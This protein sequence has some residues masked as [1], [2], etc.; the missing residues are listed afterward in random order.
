MFLSWW[1]NKTQSFSLLLWIT[2]L[3]LK[4]FQWPA[5]KTLKRWFLH[6]KGSRLWFCKIIP[7]ATCDKSILAHFPF[8]QWEV[9]TRE[10]RPIKE[11]LI[12]INI[13]KISKKF[14]RSKQKVNSWIGYWKA[15]ERPWKPSAH[16]QKVLIRMFRPSNKYQSRDTIPLN[17]QSNLLCY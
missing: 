6:R 7:E 2:Y 12:L 4:S 3:F 14:Q 11:K 17:N 9:G 5:S 1:K 10:H 8:S 16:T 15:L 13:F